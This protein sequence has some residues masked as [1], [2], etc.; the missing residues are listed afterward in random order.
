MQKWKPDFDPSFGKINRTAVWLR[1]PSLPIEYFN[2]RAL[3]EAGNLI[4]KLI[5]CDKTTESSERG[6]FARICV[7]VNL[8]QPF[9]PRVKIGRSWRKVEY[10]GLHSICFH[11]GVYGHNRDTCSKKDSPDVEIPVNPVSEQ[12]GEQVDSTDSGFGPWM[13]VPQRG[14]RLPAVK[15]FSHNSNLHSSTNQRTVLAN[16][17]NVEVGH[18]SSDFTHPLKH[19]TIQTPLSTLP[20]NSDMDCTDL[21]NFDCIP[22]LDL[23]KPPDILGERVPVI[24]PLAHEDPSVSVSNL[25]TIQ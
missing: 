24:F 16:V 3:V 25:Q 22:I 13:L 18:S 23:D 17:T 12:S 21:Q 20:S 7:E 14:M 5:K 15:P 10:E 9:V 11:C 19:V 2:S 8:N 6:K 1:F 4:G